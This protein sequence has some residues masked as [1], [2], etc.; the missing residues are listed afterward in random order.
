MW[1]TAKTYPARHSREINGYYE[2]RH[3]VDGKNLTSAWRFTRPATPLASAGAI[4]V[5]AG[6]PTP[7]AFCRWPK[8]I[9]VRYGNDCV[10]KLSMDFTPTPSGSSERRMRSWA[11]P[12]G[13]WIAL[14]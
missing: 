10:E 1:P 6:S 11:V 4:T 5:T 12:T 3:F 14:E 13:E 2:W 9:L 7:V 8:Q